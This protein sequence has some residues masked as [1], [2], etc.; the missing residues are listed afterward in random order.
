MPDVQISGQTVTIERF[1]LA[2]AMRVITLLQ[3]IQKQVPD[4]TKEWAVYR[5]QYADE[6]GTE[7]D[8]IDAKARF[9]A[10]LEGISDEEWERAGQ[11][12]R[13][14]GSPST[15]EVFFQMAPVIYERA[16][17]VTLRLLGL[18]AMENELVNRYVAKGDI[19][20]RVDELV[21]EIIRP[22]ALD[23]IMELALVAAEVIDG[24]VLA[25][26]QTVK[27]RAGN[28]ARLF[29]FK[30]KN[31][32]T[33]S[34]TSNESPEQPNTISVSPSPDSSDGTPTESDDLSGIS[35]R[36]SAPSSPVSVS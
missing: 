21:D 33:T 25:K 18:I 9:G 34:E 12:L 2:K 27:E 10:A 32:S 35:S 29:G 20:E 36:T 24:Q 26:A 14:P 31:D 3:L 17:A 11:K 6:Y 23:E 28:V 15:A 5:K 13:I 7:I 4:V 22:A 16:E 19:W 30:T 1:T 8:R